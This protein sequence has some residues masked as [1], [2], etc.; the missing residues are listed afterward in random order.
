MTTETISSR[1]R[2]PK[3][4]SCVFEEFLTKYEENLPEGIDSEYFTLIKKLEKPFKNIFQLPKII[5]KLPMNVVLYLDTGV[6]RKLFLIPLF[7][8]MPAL[9][10]SIEAGILLESLGISIFFAILALTGILVTPLYM[11]YGYGTFTDLLEAKR[12]PW[13]EKSIEREF[14]ISYYRRWP[15][16]PLYVS[17][18][19]PFI[20]D[21]QLFEIWLSHGR[22]LV[23]MVIRSIFLMI[24]H[25]GIAL[26]LYV[27]L[28]GLN[29]VRINSKLYDR[30]LKTIKERA[31]GY[32]EGHDSIL[33]KNNYEVVKVLA[34]TPG[35]S[36]QSLGNIPLYGLLAAT[37]ILNS[38]VFLV[39]SP[40]FI[41]IVEQA[42]QSS[43]NST[44]STYLADKGAASLDALTQEERSIGLGLASSAEINAKSTIIRNI[45][46]VALLLSLILS[47]SQILLPIIS[48]SNVMGR[49]RTKALKELDPFIYEEITNL[50]L[51]RPKR[52]EIDL[53]VI[54][55]LR[56][57]IYSMRPSPVNPFRLLYFSLLF[58]AYV[59][60]G[61]PAIIKL[62]G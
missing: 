42:G 9:I 16:I 37:I 57:F 8:A 44:L 56:E 58:S 24:G 29:F 35:L 53:Q 51:G 39:S 54:F 17:F 18:I 25:F 22:T 60:R 36:I 52:T 59:F 43:F 62:I 61:I 38:L 46:M 10:L 7:L 32:N 47:F 31:E 11:K 26:I 28:V 19:V 12:A 34:D 13:L 4:I 33:S 6:F 48:I 49:F 15:K 50:A 2:S 27:S 5:S 3:D 21:V 14:K 45:V 23:G 55:I 1:P 30:L 41:S 40:F 20:L